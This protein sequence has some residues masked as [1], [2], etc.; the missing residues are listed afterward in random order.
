MHVPWSRGESSTGFCPGRQRR[1]AESQDSGQGRCL[2]GPRCIP[3]VQL[4]A[5]RTEGTYSVTE[6]IELV[7][8]TRS[9]FPL[10]PHANSYFSSS[11]LRE[12]P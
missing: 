12:Q 6:G 10:N 2:S 7:S 11:R 1:G 8:D 9:A 4:R 5:R 3:S